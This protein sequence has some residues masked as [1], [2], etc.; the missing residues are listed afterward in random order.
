MPKP[1]KSAIEIGLEQT[2]ARFMN[3]LQESGADAIIVITT[4]TQGKKSKMVYQRNGNEL[5]CDAMLKHAFHLETLH[6]V[7]ES[8]KLDE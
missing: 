4:F 6:Y 5:L 1:R 8:D 2:C 7:E 3:E